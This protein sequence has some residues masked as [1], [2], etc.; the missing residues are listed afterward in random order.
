MKTIR[1]LLKWHIG[2]QLQVILKKEWKLSE[3]II[4]LLKKEQRID[5]KQKIN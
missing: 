2:S 5:N 4:I 3:L 1:S